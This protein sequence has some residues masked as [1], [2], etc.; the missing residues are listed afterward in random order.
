MFFSPLIASEICCLFIK[1]EC[2]TALCSLALPV[3]L[4]SRRAKQRD[5][6]GGF[7]FSGEDKEAGFK[8]GVS[9]SPG[10]QANGGG[11]SRGRR[12]S[13][14][15]CLPT[16]TGLRLISQEENPPPHAPF[17]QQNRIKPAENHSLTPSLTP[18]TQCQVA[19]TAHVVART[20]H[21]VPM[22]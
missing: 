17:S 16:Q 6:H 10:E 19:R 14:T 1:S 2:F 7:L 12:A 13:K 9:A 20:A 4:F 15:T 22:Q 11:G 21:V 18:Y 5:A 3:L 8:E